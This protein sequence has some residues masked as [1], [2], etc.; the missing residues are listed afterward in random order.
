[1][2]KAT[3]YAILWKEKII[4]FRSTIGLVL[5]YFLLIVG[6]NIYMLSS[7]INDPSLNGYIEN[8]IINN[9]IMLAPTVFMAIGSVIVSQS[10]S[11]DKREGIL[12]ILLGNGTR[13]DIIW[14]GKYIFSVIICY[15]VL[16]A[17]VFVYLFGIRMLYDG[18][19][20]LSTSNYVLIFVI[21]PIVSMLL[22]ALY[23]FIFWITK[24]QT[25]Q[26]FLS[27]FPAA[28]YLVSFYVSDYI[29]EKK[30][31][32]KIGVAILVCSLSVLG[33]CILNKCVQKYDVEKLV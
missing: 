13:S 33:V 16:L 28:I 2:Y 5:F 11:I 29:I 7:Y 1:M 17:S 12:K 14:I 30:V 21:L 18:Y 24:N 26:I 10:I 6:A 25:V 9:L 19:I 8:I 20:V 27:M 31:D 3:L 4:F 32:T 22:L 23:A 15:I